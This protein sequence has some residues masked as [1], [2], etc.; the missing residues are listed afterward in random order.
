MQSSIKHIYFLGI[1]GIGMSALARYFHLSGAKVAGYDR[2]P[3]IVTEALQ[4]E[5]IEVF[6]SQDAA[7]LEGV[8]H[9]VYTPA[10]KESIIFEAA[11]A[12]NIPIMKRAQI[13][14]EVCKNLQTLGVAGTHGKTT[15]SSM[16][17][18]F[19]R[20]CKVECTAFLGGISR[21]LNG[22]FVYGESGHCVVE[23]DEFDR[24][25]LTLFPQMAI[26]TSVDADHLDIYG[27]A[28]AVLESYQL[29]VN[30]VDKDGFVLIHADIKGIDWGRK[31]A[32][33][34]IEAGEYRAENVRFGTLTTSFDY[35]SPTHR[36][37]NLTLHMPG[38]H[39][40]SNAVAAITLTLQA[41]GE[42]ESVATA[43]SSFK[44]I[45]RRFEVQMHSEQL[46]FIDDYAHHPTE[47]AAAIDTAKSLF[48]ERQLVVIFQPHLFTRTRDFQEGFAA[49]LSIPDV[50][51]LLPIYP[52][53]ELPIAG[54]NSEMLLSQMTQA[55]KFLI[56]K[57][58]ICQ[59]LANCVKMPSVILTVGAGDIDRELGKIKEW[60]QAQIQ[61]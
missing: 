43:V 27:S 32:T 52:A 5:G 2:S 6:F 37:K 33:Y 34:G 59:T 8:T 1:G 54:V 22:N 38:R 29:F 51:L 57:D 58:A 20:T 9:L 12:H 16:L 39:N 47:L 3:S 28:S 60:A 35:V 45:Y 4:A 15:T 21:N 10:I 53:R 23:A 48:P 55:D 18:H 24:S 11:K 26:L 40:V 46:T 42:V 31:Y 36:I 13:L 44:G 50:T 7:Q 14:G 30:Q 49:A 25:F 61:T 41:G 19:M 17:T 56:E